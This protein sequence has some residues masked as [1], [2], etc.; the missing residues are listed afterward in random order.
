MQKGNRQEQQII[1]FSLA[2]VSDF[3]NLGIMN[4][5]NQRAQEKMKT[6]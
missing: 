2:E 1:Q 3:I 4:M 5:N 6:K